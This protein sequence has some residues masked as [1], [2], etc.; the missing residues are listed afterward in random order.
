MY[1]CLFC[2]DFFTSRRSQASTARDYEPGRFFL[3]LFLPHS[4]WLR[5]KTAE[6]QLNIWGGSFQLPS[7]QIQFIFSDTPIVGET[8]VK[9]LHGIV[10]HNEVSVRITGGL[11]GTRSPSYCHSP[12]DISKLRVR[13]DCPAALKCHLNL[14]CL[15][16]ISKKYSNLKYINKY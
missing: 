13:G 10:S 3:F 9:Y 1:V 4:K 2:L 7:K 8:F 15:Y 14:L 6:N 16:D 5:D 11:D 12:P